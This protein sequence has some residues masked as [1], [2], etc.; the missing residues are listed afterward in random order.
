MAQPRVQHPAR[1]VPAHDQ[2]VEA[3]LPRVL[4]D[5]ARGVAGL[6]ELQGHPLALRVR[7]ESLVLAKVSWANR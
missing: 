6:R 3:M 4:A 7:Q 2:Q 1:S 5:G